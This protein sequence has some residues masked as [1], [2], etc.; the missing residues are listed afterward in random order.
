QRW[1]EILEVPDP[2]PGLPVTAAVR[3]FG[4]GMALASVGDVSAA[5]AEADSLAAVRAALPADYPWGLNPA[6]RV[7]GV[8][9]AVLAA[10]LAAARGEPSIELWQKAVA[11]E[12][13]L[14]YDEPP[15]WYL[16]VREELGGAWL[17]RGDAA[18]AEEVYRQELRKNPESG[19][20][21]L[22]LAESLRRERKSAEA[23]RA[24]ARFRAA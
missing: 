9:Q 6:P 2:G 16:P 21:L 23:A 5:Q 22:G 7:L 11:L 4:R 15:G 1:S 19:R 3:R 18:R 8:A 24:M 20:A 10:R 12:D 17:A 13:S 14:G